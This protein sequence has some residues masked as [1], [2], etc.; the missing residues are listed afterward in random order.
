MKKP[1]IVALILLIVSI[2]S[3][4]F[5]SFVSPSRIKDILLAFTTSFLVSTIAQIVDIYTKWVNHKEDRYL[6]DM[7]QYGIE[8]LNF[9]KQF[10]LLQSIATAQHSIWMSGY[11]HI[12]TATLSYHLSVAAERGVKF[13]LLICPPWSD[14][15]KMV[16]SNNEEINRSIKN[17][18]K[19]IESILSHTTNITNLEI[20][21]CNNVLFN[22]IYKIDNTFITSSYNHLS[23]KIKTARDFFTLV[24]SQDNSR[25]YESLTT[26]Y[27]QLWK[28]SKPVDIKELQTLLKEYDQ[29]KMRLNDLYFNL[30]TKYSD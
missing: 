15:F 14:A 24:T 6:I 8:K 22:D 3:I 28:S 23:E 25:F 7:N 20:R 21:F 29:E 19:I 4:V 16:Y 12:L 11:R 5:Y 10:F 17:Y 13:R 9:N 2:V 1:I 30:S 27:E 26:E 18:I